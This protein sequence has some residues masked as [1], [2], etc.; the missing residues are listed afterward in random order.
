M[1]MNTSR[2]DEESI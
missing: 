1:N 2:V